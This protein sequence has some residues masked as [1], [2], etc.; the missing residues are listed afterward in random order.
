MMTRLLA[1]L[2]LAAAG[3]LQAQERRV[4]GS[5]RSEA[6]SGAVAAALV[7]VPGTIIQ[8]RTDSSGRFEFTRPF[9]GGF[10]LIVSALGFLPDTVAVTAETDSILAS[11]VPSAVQ[12]A[13]VEVE[14]EASV[15]R[16][17][18]EDLAQLSTITLSATEL[19]RVPTVME[20][21]VIRAIQLLPGTVAK[22]DFSIGFNVRGGEDDQNLIQVDGIT[23]FNPSHMA[24]LFSTFDADA[25]G[26]TD[27]LTGGFPAG[28]SGRLSSVL[29]IGIRDGDSTRIRAS[30]LISLLSSKL[31]F[32]GPIRN[33][34][35]FLLTA[36]R[37][38]MDVVARTIKR[39]LPYYFTDLLGKVSTRGPNDGRITFTGYWGRDALNLKLVDSTE[40][41]DRVDLAF[42]WGNRL[43]GVTWQLPLE[44]ARLRTRA[45]VSN[46]T[47]TLGLLPDLIRYDNAALLLSGSSALAFN[48]WTGHQVEVGAGI[49][50]YA[51]RLDL[52]SPAIGTSLMHS[53]YRTTVASAFIDEQWSAHRKL[54]VRPG[55]RVEHVPQA[56]FTGISPRVAVKYFLSTTLALTASAGRYYQPVH[57]IRDQ[58]FPIT[59]FESWI[60]ADRNV[61]VGRADHAVLGIEKWMY[62]DIQL[63]LEGYHK[64]YKNLASPNP[65][66]DLRRQGDEFDPATGTASGVDFLLRRH[67]GAIRGWIAYTFVKTSRTTGD[68]TY[69]PSHDRRHTF[70]VV[71]E[72][73]GPLHSRLTVRWGYG[74]PL[75]YTEFVGQWEHRR[76]NPVTHVFDDTNDEPIAGPRN[77]A[78]YPHYTR[79]D[80]GMR[81]S[82]RKWGVQWEPYFQVVNVYNRRNVFLYFFDFEAIPPTRT[83]LSQLPILPTFGVEIRL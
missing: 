57:S 58:E 79:L 72:A 8:V 3:T 44:S 7:T 48:P 63:T 75:P 22:N 2:S 80:A 82:F 41:S 42:N 51:M 4:S 81:W 1:L 61:P 46:Y 66:Q 6:D 56:G 67:A 52:V 9:P 24:G 76:Y 31:M 64:R 38:Y 36:R 83:G 39:N 30:S 26:R 21:D 5:V 18:F 32:E 59:I 70:N 43:A 50:Q 11:L 10:R 49:E 68:L 37:T 17:R 16:S 45:S 14:S 69:P 27:F 62:R 20:P 15:A 40:S 13:P 29:D 74:S 35:S 65:V 12:L 47:T 53:R 73:P 78:R 71:F 55:V 28:Y 34:T 23:V 77:G 33:G 19:R 60:S 54:L 25:V